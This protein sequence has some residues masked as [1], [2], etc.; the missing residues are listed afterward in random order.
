MHHH[1]VQYSTYSTLSTQL[2]LTK[3]TLKVLILQESVSCDWFQVL[4]QSHCSSWVTELL[5][6]EEGSSF[7]NNY[8]G[9]QTDRNYSRVWKKRETQQQ[10]DI[11]LSRHV[12]ICMYLI[13]VYEKL[14]GTAVVKW[15]DKLT[16]G[17]LKLN[18]W[19]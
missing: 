19:K 15:V 11:H 14:V 1:P 17:M 9:R 2:L 6:Q 18:I 13:N 7:H 10:L 3:C 12:L 16:A 8:Q 4:K 5:E